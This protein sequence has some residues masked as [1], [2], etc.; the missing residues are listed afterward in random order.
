MSDSIDYRS[1]AKEDAKNQLVLVSRLF[2]AIGVG[3]L[4]PFSALT[5]PV[6][7][8]LEVFPSEEIEV[9]ITALFWWVN[10]LALGALVSF[11]VFTRLQRADLQ[12]LSGIS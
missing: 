3:Y 7:Y 4:F 1:T 12:R 6:D 11:T 5:Q 9:N 8:W 10:L 2:A